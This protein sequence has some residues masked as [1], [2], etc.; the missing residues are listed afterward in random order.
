MARKKQEELEEKIE[1]MA[2]IKTI[3]ANSVNCVCL[4]WEECFQEGAK[5]RMSGQN[6]NVVLK[7]GVPDIPAASGRNAF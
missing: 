6:D 3:L 5:S 4:T 2:R 7:A 1:K